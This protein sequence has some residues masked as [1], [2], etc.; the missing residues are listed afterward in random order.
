MKTSADWDIRY[1]SLPSLPAN[2]NKNWQDLNGNGTLKNAII[3]MAYEFCLQ[4]DHVQGV[5]SFWFFTITELDRRQQT[6]KLSLELTIKIG[7]NLYY[8]SFLPIF[9]VVLKVEHSCGH[10]SHYFCIAKDDQFCPKKIPCTCKKTSLNSSSNQHT[11][12]MQMETWLSKAVYCTGV[13]IFYAKQHR[14]SY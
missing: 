9:H 5:C 6:L 12:V 8:Y 2:N 4:T 1:Y 7:M 3:F 14:G 10:K 11:P 13:H